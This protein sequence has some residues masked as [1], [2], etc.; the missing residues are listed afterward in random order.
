M[1]TPRIQRLPNGL[2]VVLVE[3]RAAPVV[4]IQAWVQVGSADETASEAGLAHLHEHML[5]KGTKRRAPGEIARDVEGRGGEINAWTSFDQ[6]VY[7]LVLAS[8]FFEDGVEILADAVQESTFDEGELAREIEVVVE[9]IKRS[10]DMPSRRVSRELFSLAYGAHPYRWPV[11]G[12]EQSVR[13][14][15]RPQILDFYRRH[16]S[17]EKLVL[18]L[19]GD[20]DAQAALAQVERHW[21]GRAPA[22]TA[23]IPARATEPPQREARVRLLRDDVR[24]A[25]LSIGWHIPGMLDP[26]LAALDLLASILGQG[27]SSRLSLSVKRRQRLAAEAHAYAYTPKDPGL[28]TVGLTVAGVQA[29][30]ALEATLREV[31][32]LRDEPPTVAELAAAKRQALSDAI[33]Q[34]ETVQGHAR[35]VGFYQ[36]A[37]G[38]LAFEDEYLDRVQRLGAE[39]IRE[40]ALRYLTPENATIV[41]LLSTGIELG[42]DEARGLLQAEL[43]PVAARPQAA[44]KAAQPPSSPR[45]AARGASRPEPL[46]VSPLPGGGTLLIKRD[47]SVP[48]VAFRAVTPGGL[49]WETPSDNGIHQLLAMTL[50][51]GAAGK[52]AEEIARAVDGLAGSVGASAGR[53]SFGLRGEFLSQHAAEGFELFLDCLLS[54]TLAEDEV[55]KE[56]ELLL[57][58]IRTRD[59]N[60]QGVAFDLFAHTLFTRHPYRQNLAGELSS[61]EKLSAAALRR[62]WERLLAP[63]GLTLA[64]VGDV[65][66]AAIAEA[67]GRALDRFGKGARGAPSPAAPPPEEPRPQAPRSARRSLA[68]AQSHLLLGFLGLRLADPTRHAL[69]LLSTVLS[70]QG[71]RLFVELRDKRSMAYSVTSL[72]LEGLDPGYF[73]VYLG[74]SPEKVTDAVEGVR[75]ELSRARDELVPG[76]ELERAKRHLIGTHEI[77]MQR[78]ASQAAAMALDQAYGF[79]PEDHLHYAERNEAVTAQAIRD[80]TQRV[81]DPRGEVLAIVGPEP[82]A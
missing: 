47:A 56:R 46:R 54:P 18:A 65:D 58:D 57:Q 37:A 45:L 68:K 48:V 63:A 53:N 40:A 27:D 72:T 17:P 69:E 22:P 6:T 28:F 66:P 49:R 25:Q 15:R 73:A 42:D 10:E 78:R 77:G 43:R 21:G 1:S 5:F 23:A 4:A 2:T 7:H 38:S 55:A 11:I 34:H 50:T 61:V 12:T 79:G 30:P 13:S 44:R 81:L 20:V 26:D 24:E 33:Y 76:P 31:Q 62:H 71:G 9:E 60:P 39:E 29:R 19:V 82:T 67:A 14:F 32:R 70:G 8:R 41:G 64:V 52:S 80:V 59:D 3:N 36:S 51:R 74:T 75:Q 35:K 16:Y